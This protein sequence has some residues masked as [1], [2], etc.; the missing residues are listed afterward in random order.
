MHRELTYNE[1]VKYIHDYQ[2]NKYT[3]MDQDQ[4]NKKLK[5]MLNANLDLIEKKHLTEDEVIEIVRLWYTNGM[6]EGILQDE[7]GLDL[8][9]IC[10]QL[11]YNK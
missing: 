4:F 9:E 7:D 5:K 2:L 11:L 6:Y 1:W 3:Q 10:E 8:E